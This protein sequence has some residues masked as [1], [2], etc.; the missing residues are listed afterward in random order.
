M[1]VI[2][3]KASCPEHLGDDEHGEGI[4]DPKALGE[5]ERAFQAVGED[6]RRQAVG[7]RRGEGQRLGVG[8]EGEDRGDRAEGFLAVEEAVGGQPGDDGRLEVEVR[9]QA[10]CDA[11]PREDLGVAG[12]R[13]GH[14]FGHLVE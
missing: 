14:V 7:A 11:A 1:P 8:V 5:V 13:V 2:W 3:V 6:R 10:G 9:R 4:V 12:P